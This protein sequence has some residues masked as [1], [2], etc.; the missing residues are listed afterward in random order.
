[1]TCVCEISKDSKLYIN[2]NIIIYIC[3]WPIEKYMKAGQFWGK[4][5]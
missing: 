5:Q 4:L 1:M 2:K 3:M